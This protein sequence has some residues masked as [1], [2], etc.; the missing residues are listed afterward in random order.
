MIFNAKSSVKVTTLNRQNTHTQ[1]H[2]HTF[3]HTHTHTHL[4]T[5]TYLYTHSHLYTHTHTHTYLYTHTHTN[6]QSPVT[7]AHTIQGS[8]CTCARARTHTHTFIYSHTHTHKQSQ[9]TTTT[10]RLL[11][12]GI[13]GV[14]GDKLLVVIVN[15]ADAPHSFLGS[16]VCWPGHQHEVSE[17]VVILADQ[18]HCKW[19]R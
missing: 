12:T 5:H 17:C 11:L 19:S 3:I 7:H 15:E 1:T 10:N 9:K 6:F 8:C 4:Y 13:A 14:L 18:L 2:T 16:V